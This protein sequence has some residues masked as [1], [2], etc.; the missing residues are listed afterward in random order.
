MRLHLPSIKLDTKEIYKNV[1]QYHS[2]YNIF[3]LGKYRYFLQNY[4]TFITHVN[5]GLKITTIFKCINKYFKCLNL[6]F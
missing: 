2:F 4:V 1:K 3:S 6:N 5:N